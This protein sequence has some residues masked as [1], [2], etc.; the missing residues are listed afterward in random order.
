M[1]SLKAVTGALLIG[2]VSSF[3][4]QP[5][6]IGHKAGFPVLFVYLEGKYFQLEE[7]EGAV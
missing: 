2:F 5:S 1:F 3:V 6:F 4:N 7:Q